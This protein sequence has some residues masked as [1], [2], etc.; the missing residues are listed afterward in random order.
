[1]NRGNESTR[2]LCRW[3]VA[4]AVAA[5]LAPIP[6]ASAAP[7][8]TDEYRL[9]LQG[10]RVNAVPAIEPDGEPDLSLDRPQSGV[11]GERA[12]TPSVLSGAAAAASGAPIALLGGIVGLLWLTLSARSRRQPSR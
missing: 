9:D 2:R 4:A 11:A 8:A 10:A 1:M 7:P 6:A 5:C 3:G 12:S